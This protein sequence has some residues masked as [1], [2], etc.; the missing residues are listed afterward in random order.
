MF[1]Y[2]YNDLF[3]KNSASY[4]LI[5]LHL[6]IFNIVFLMFFFFQGVIL[7]HLEL[8]LCFIQMKLIFKNKKYLF[9]NNIDDIFDL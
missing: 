8:F 3:V 6:F 7:I 9:L 2:F 4:D 5:T 1:W